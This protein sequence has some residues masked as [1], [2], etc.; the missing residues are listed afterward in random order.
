MFCSGLSTAI[1]IRGNELIISN[2]DMPVTG[3]VN[4]KFETPN[5]VSVFSLEE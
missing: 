5:T 1:A 2:F 3:G 4:T